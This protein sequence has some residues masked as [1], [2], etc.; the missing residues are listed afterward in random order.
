MQ[1]DETEVHWKVS[2]R[3]VAFISLMFE[4]GGKGT[5]E[6]DYDCVLAFTIT[7]ICSY[8]TIN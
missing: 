8:I 3:A 2:A 4:G 7:G 5:I 6:R 1:L